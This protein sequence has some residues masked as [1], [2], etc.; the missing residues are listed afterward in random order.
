MVRRRF[1]TTKR[2]PHHPAPEDEQ[3][4][5]G[6]NEPVTP[7]SPG[8]G[9]VG[10]ST[11]VDSPVQ[12][13]EDI[14]RDRASMK[15]DDDDAQGRP[16]SR[17]SS[18]PTS[19]GAD[20]VRRSSLHITPPAKTLR[21]DDSDDDVDEDMDEH[22][23]DHPSTYKPAPWIWVPKD[24]L[25][26]SDVLLEELREAGVDASDLGA[27]M[28]EKARVRVKSVLIL[29][30]FSRA[31]AHSPLPFYRRGPPVRDLTEKSNTYL[32]PS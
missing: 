12:P 26:L 32:D 21:D 7:V 9:T 14:P 5:E 4:S 18:H 29:F 11:V 27:S 8:A 2:P 30:G 10:G 16:P 17:A 23:F 13:P 20:A 31:R 3:E 15:S 19:D 1:R 6:V 22:A 24:P 25:G 28:N